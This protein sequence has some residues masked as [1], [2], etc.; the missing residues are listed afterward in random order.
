[1]TAKILDALKERVLVLDG[2]MGT[3]LHA[4]DLDVQEDYDGLENCCE[5][6]NVTRPDIVR[7]VHESFLAVGC[8]AVE[9]NTFGGMPHV[10]VEFGLEERVEEIN[11]AAV[12]VAREAAEAYSTPERPRFVI[13]SMGPGTKLTSLGQIPYAE[14]RESYGEQ[15]RALASAGVDAFLIETV[16]DDA[17]L[18]GREFGIEFMTSSYRFVEYDPFTGQWAEVPGDDLYR[19]R[20]LPPG[21]EFELFIDEK[22]IPLE[23]DPKQ[24]AD[25]D[26][27][28]LM[29]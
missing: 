5:I 12:R 21:I 9:T 26:V 17:M 16:Q 22:R 15:A 4:H 2:A 13:G 7:S 8:D 11:H 27:R 18:Q 23:T 24:L 25:P 29:E 20:E 1:M 10:L 28:A 19:I 6:L 3:S 14:L